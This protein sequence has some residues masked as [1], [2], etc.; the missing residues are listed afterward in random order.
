M[1]D[2]RSTTNSGEEMYCR[3][4]SKTVI[5]SSCTGSRK[6]IKPS[7]VYHTKVSQSEIS[8]LYQ[9]EVLKFST[10]PPVILIH[11][12][13]T[14][15]I[16]KTTFP[17]FK[18][19]SEAQEWILFAIQSMNLDK[20][21]RELLVHRVPE[22]TGMI[23]CRLRLTFGQYLSTKYWMIYPAKQILDPYIMQS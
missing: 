1:K 21:T 23:Q 22:I 18:P 2:I 16:D 11:T 3:E 5:L 4:I 12:C 6:G 20:L 13:H 15:K 7:H 10:F 9:L 19:L 14:L 8:K 17:L